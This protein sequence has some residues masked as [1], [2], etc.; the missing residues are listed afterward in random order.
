MKNVL[1]FICWALTHVDPESIPEGATLPLP[2]D[3]CGIEPWHYLYGTVRSR[4][5]RDKIAERWQNYYSTHGW[6][7]ESYDYATSSF[8]EK[9]YATDC[10]GLCDAYL[11]EQGEKTDINANMN[12][13]SWCTDK[14]KISEID[15]PYVIGEALFSY[16]S[17]K[18]KMTHVG[19]ICGFDVNGEP[20]AVEA[21]GIWHGVVVTKLSDRAWTHRG[22]MTKKF[23]YESED[24]DMVKPVILAKTSPM[25]QGDGIRKLQEALNALGYKDDE[26]RS[27]DEDGKCGNCT[28]QAV[29]S[30]ANAHADT[31]QSDETATP[32]ASFLSVNGSYQLVVIPNAANAADA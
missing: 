26:G 3:E 8:G 19:W 28:M 20:L 13:T 16:N 30:F 4:T 18:D 21:R 11:T 9:D 2:L 31:A 6:S 7:K 12:Y 10:Q 5:T 32:L 17:N 24:T 23:N 1:N 15:R 27:L 29:R 22:L 14:G 25:I